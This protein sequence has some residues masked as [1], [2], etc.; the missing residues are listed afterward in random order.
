M[1]KSNRFLALA[2]G[3]GMAVSMAACGGNNGGF[4]MNET[5]ADVTEITILAGDMDTYQTDG[6]DKNTPVYQAL[7]QAVGFDVYARTGISNEQLPER[8]KLAHT[9]GN[10]PEVFRIHGP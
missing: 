4:D 6:V 3:A 2:L 8:I 9:A 10:L 5:A 1:K 7:K